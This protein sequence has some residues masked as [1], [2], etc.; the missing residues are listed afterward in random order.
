MS[1]QDKGEG[2]QHPQ[3]QP[4]PHAQ[5]Q[6]ATTEVVVDDSGTLPSYSNFCRVTATP[7]EVILDFGLNAQP[8]ATGRQDIK[9]SERIVMNLYTSKRLLTALGMTIQRHEQTFGAIELDV[10]RRV[11]QSHS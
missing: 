11:S 1:D 5:G 2:G 9:A 10:R 7:E 3:A 6:Q 8:F 4:Q